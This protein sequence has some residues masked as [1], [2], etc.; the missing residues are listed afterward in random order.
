M[1]C[2]DFQILS[3]GCLGVMLLISKLLG[4]NVIGVARGLRDLRSHTKPQFGRDG[5][6]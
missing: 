2:S 3:V 6:D 5:S 4:G 1:F